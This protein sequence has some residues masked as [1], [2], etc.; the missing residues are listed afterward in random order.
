MIDGM[1]TDAAIEAR[2]TEAATGYRRHWA[3][4]LRRAALSL[5]SEL[6]LDEART[7]VDVGCGVGTLLSDLR[8]RAP[9]ALVVGV[10]RTEAM[11][12]LAPCEAARARMDARE[13]GFGDARFDIALMT[14][15]LFHLDDPLVGL[16]ELRRIIRPGGKLGIITWGP[17]RDAWQAEIIVREELDLLGAAPEGPPIAHHELVDSPAK[18]EALARNAGFSE[19]RAWRSPLGASYAVAT[20]LDVIAAIGRSRARIE[21]L[22]RAG[23]NTFRERAE[24]RLTEIPGDRLIDPATLVYLVASTT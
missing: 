13:L 21:S 20:Y 8:E 7:V 2:Y 16:R 3:P 11:L 4:R 19:V 12:R 15:A 17:D 14:Y 5:L 18:L 1:S 23:R 10:D 24:R 6:P 9:S 22:G